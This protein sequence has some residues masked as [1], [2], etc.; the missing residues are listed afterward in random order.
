MNRLSAISA[1]FPEEFMFQL[2][3]EEW[4][5]MWSQIATTS[6]KKRRKDHLPYAFTEH[7]VVMLASVLKSEKAIEMNIAIVKAFIAL[8]QVISFHY[9]LA[10]QLNELRDRL[11]EH[12]TQLAAIYDTIE[13]LLDK[14]VE[15]EE[16]QRIWMNRERIGFKTDTKDLEKN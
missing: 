14:K 7:G 5:N 12:D 11:G 4:E 8:R 1:G 13:N 6:L 2:T 15:E 9:D 16:R 3:E 10:G